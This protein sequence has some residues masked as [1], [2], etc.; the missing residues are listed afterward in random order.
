MPSWRSRAPE[1]DAALAAADHQ[2]VGV[3]VPAE[4]VDLGGARLLPGDPVLGRAVLHA[5]GP[6]RALRLLVALELV[7]RGEQ[8]PGAL[9][10][11]AQQARARGPTAVSN[12]IHAV[13]TPSASSGSSPSVIRKSVAS[14]V[15]IVC[16][17]Q[18]GDALAAL[19]GRDVPGERDEVAPE[20]RSWRTGPQRDRRPARRAPRRSR[21]ATSP[22]VAGRATSCA[23][24]LDGLGH[25]ALLRSGAR[26]DAAPTSR[27][28][29]LGRRRKRQRRPHR[30]SEHA[31]GRVGV[32]ERWV[33]ARVSIA[34]TTTGWIRRTR[35]K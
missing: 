25:G 20:R 34:A 1:R 4:A 9:V 31:R 23:L 10:V 2:D 35:A 3:A 27:Q 8:R 22:R 15:S 12:R 21:T 33:A 6:G 7:Q 24:R 29:D 13:T 19:D 5:L 17:E 16:A 30:M 18:V 32:R 11:Q 28:L 26:S 14:V